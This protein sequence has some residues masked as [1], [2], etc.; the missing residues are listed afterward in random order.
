MAIGGSFEGPATEIRAVSP[1]DS[2]DLT[3]CRG[4]FYTGTAGDVAVKTIHGNSA[5][6][7][8][9]I[10]GAPQNTIIPIMLTRIMST[11]TTATQIYALF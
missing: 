5:E 4:F 2:T 7:A 1:S 6:T 3:G 10:S 8:V 11:N 9:T